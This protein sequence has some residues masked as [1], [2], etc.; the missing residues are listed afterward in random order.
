MSKTLKKIISVFLA[1]AMLTGTCLISYAADE[2]KFYEHQNFYEI[3]METADAKF[4]NGDTFIYILYRPNCI[5]CYNM[6]KRYFSVWMNSYNATIYGTDVSE[7]NSLPSFIYADYYDKSIVTP[8]V[9]FVKNGSY[10]AVMACYEG[11]ARDLNS[12]FCGLNGKTY[13]PVT[14]ATFSEKSV[15]VD[16]GKTKKLTV[17]IQP[18]NASIKAIYWESS[19][20]ETATV[21]QDGVVTGK[22]GGSVTIYARLADAD[23]I[24]VPDELKPYCRVKVNVPVTGIS[25]PQKN[26]TLT[27]GEEM[28]LKPIYTPEDATPSVL[29][30]SS[31]NKNVVDTISGKKIKAVAPGTAVITV[32]SPDKVYSDTCTVTV[33]AK[34]VA[35]TGVSL[36]TGSVSLEKGKTLMLN[37]TVSPSNATNKAVTWSSSNSSVVSVSSS[38]LMTAKAAGTATVTVKT[39]DGGYT[40][41]CTVTVT[42]AQKINVTSVDVFVETDFNGTK[43]CDLGFT[44]NPANATYKSVKWTTSNSD[45]ATVDSNGVVTTYGNP[46]QAIITVT[47]TNYDG[48]TVS[49][50]ATV[51]VT[52]GESDDSSD[53]SSGGFFGLIG[54]IFELLFLPFTL[55]FSILFG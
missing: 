53:D 55:L 36:S 49:D 32:Y 1:F 12:A 51:T 42:E 33:V 2:P 47:I 52:D 6:G 10:T 9:L 46:G 50:T 31:S 38:G 44:V 14:S 37:Y 27:V 11:V 54:A 22:K 28:E 21:S 45:V 48:T 23:I 26:V 39:N 4:N 8:L 5:N 34:K 35:V 25:L 17:D 19:D 18:S 29:Y 30:Y 15:S 7:L 43:V 16:K 13:V 41:K 40:A 3:S 24:G 20:P